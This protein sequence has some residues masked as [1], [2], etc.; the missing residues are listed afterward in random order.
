MTTYPK[1]IEYKKA[2][3]FQGK[4]KPLTRATYPS[5]MLFF[6][7]ETYP[8]LNEQEQELQELKLGVARYIEL[9]KKGNIKKEDNL[10]F[11]N[12]QDFFNFLEI[13]TKQ[14]T[15]LHIFAHNIAF[16]LM[17]VNIFDYYHNKGIKLNP[18]IVGGFRFIWT[19]SHPNGKQMFINTGNYINTKLENIG[20]DLEFPKLDIDFNSATNEELFIYCQ[21]DVD[22]IQKFVLTLITFLKE[23]DLGSFK[24]TIASLAL[25]AYRYKFMNHDIYLHND[26]YVNTIERDCYKGGRTE[27]FFIGHVP[28][29]KIY[30]LDINS[31]YPHVM[32]SDKIPYEYKYPLNNVTLDELRNIMENHYIIADC[33]VQTNEPFLAVRWSKN[34]FKLLDDVTPP[35]GRK[36]I[37]PIGMFRDILHHD[38]LTYALSIGAIVRLNT[39]F[40]YNSDYIFDDYVRFFNKLKIQYTKEDNKSYRQFTKLYLNSLYGKWGQLFRDTMI[41]EK[42]TSETTSPVSVINLNT[43]SHYTDFIWFGDLY[44]EYD[45]GE[46]VHSF[47]AIAGCITARARMLLY[48]YIKEAGLENVYYSDTDSLYVN[49]TGYQR[50]QSH[51]S[52]TELG[53]LK[54]EETI[55]SLVINGAKDYVKNGKRVV[56]GVPVGADWLNDDVSIAMRFEG[57]KE[58]RNNGHNRQPLVWKQ[59]KIKKT[60]YDKAIVLESGRT[61]PF[62]ITN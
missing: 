1:Q 39:I 38:E 48:K 15:Q 35:L 4:L 46:S 49:E 61:T 19:V 41:I 9:D 33:V 45:N 57:F 56:K 55:T 47:P 53:K 22:I 43:G 29:N 27:A 59:L 37:F 18:P 36:L 20:R 52:A 17:V 44:R 30:A 3:R 42:N 54:L 28:E 25:S 34:R 23:N 51:I 60:K 11:T 16:D 12:K 40:V 21:R 32:I 8:I 10:Q 26:L 58:W 62:L 13:H 7:T 50:L 31:M 6:D 14:R 2:K 5:H 24:V